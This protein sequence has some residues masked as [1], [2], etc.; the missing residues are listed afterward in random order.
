MNY[1]ITH[2]RAQL[3]NL[4]DADV[5]TLHEDHPGV[6]DMEG[7]SDQAKLNSAIMHAALKAELI[8]R[9]LFPAEIY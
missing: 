8:E 1:S 4:S 2:Y 6:S 7:Y 5:Y 9:N 3:V